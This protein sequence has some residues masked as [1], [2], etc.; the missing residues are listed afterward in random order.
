[1]LPEHV[2]MLNEMWQED[3]RKEKPILDEQQKV[4]INGMLQLGLKDDLTVAVT[5]YDNYDHHT[6]EGKLLSCD[7]LGRRLKFVN[8]MEV[9]L[10]A[11]VK[12]YIP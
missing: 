7:A 4:E 3:N 6:V 12:V 5:Y 10:G 1:M 9:M 2:K 8:G 11:I